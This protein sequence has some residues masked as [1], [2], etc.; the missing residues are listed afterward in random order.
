MSHQPLRDNK[1]PRI[2]NCLACG[3]EMNWHTEFRS[4]PMA[5]WKTVLVENYDDLSV[6]IDAD[7]AE[8]MSIKTG[9]KFHIGNYPYG[10]F[11]I[12][13]YKLE[14]TLLQNCESLFKSK[15]VITQENIG[16]N[17]SINKVFYTDL[18]DY[19]EKEEQRL[20]YAEEQKRKEQFH[21]AKT[22]IAN[23]TI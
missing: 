20:A 11:T 16:G 10:F 8:A 23:E 2:K 9:E 6:G 17:A 21:Q 15:C 1:T 18:E 13:P 14:K 19:K 5:S 4:Q 7:K 12:N 3:R 22:D